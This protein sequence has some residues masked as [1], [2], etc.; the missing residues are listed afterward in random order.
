MG[1]VEYNGSMHL[2]GHRQLYGKYEIIKKDCYTAVEN[3]INSGYSEFL[4]GDYGQFDTLAASV[5]LSLRK[6]YPHITV[7][8]VLPYYPR[9]LTIM[10]K[11]VN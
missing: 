8:L 2:C 3:L 10:T 1:A 11:S 9:S 4:I 5:C 6:K 7:S